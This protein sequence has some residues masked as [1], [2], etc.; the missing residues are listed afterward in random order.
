MSAP[1]PNGVVLERLL[2]LCAVALIALGIV[3]T[4]F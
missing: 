1:P 2:T 3:T 4:F